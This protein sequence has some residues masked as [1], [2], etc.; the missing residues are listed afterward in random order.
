[1]TL[2]FET[3]THRF[4]TRGQLMHVIEMGRGD[5]KATTAK[6]VPDALFESLE[7]GMY[8]VMYA[9]VNPETDMVKCHVVVNNDVATA[10]WVEMPQDEYWTLVTKEVPGMDVDYEETSVT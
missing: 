7:D 6:D 10:V 5:W 9:K 1:M 4:L 2:G 8:P 3:R